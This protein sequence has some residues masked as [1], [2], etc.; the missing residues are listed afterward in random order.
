M[1]DEGM[2]RWIVTPVVLT[3]IRTEREWPLSLSSEM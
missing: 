3:I 1:K 2:E